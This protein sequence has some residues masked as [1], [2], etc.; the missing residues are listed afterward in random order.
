[1]EWQTPRKALAK[2]MPAMVAALC[3][4]SRALGFSGALQVGGGQVLLEQRSAC[5]A[6]ASEYS[7]AMTET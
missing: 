4:S 7:L 2:A 1:M 6:W 5:R 3:T